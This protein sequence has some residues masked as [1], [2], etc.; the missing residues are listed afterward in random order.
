MKK[1]TTKFEVNSTGLRT[2]IGPT[3]FIFKIC[4]ALHFKQSD[5]ELVKVEIRGNKS[6]FLQ[7]SSPKNVLSK[8]EIST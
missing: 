6:Y 4:L 3:F 2:R 7:P 8:L 1:V 5:F